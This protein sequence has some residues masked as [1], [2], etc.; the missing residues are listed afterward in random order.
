[1]TA[2][3]STLVD[4]L[5]RQ[6]ALRPGH[7]AIRRGERVL[8]FADLD[9]ESARLAQALR[10]MGVM[11]GDRVAC[12]S[13]H[14]IE[15]LLLTLAACRL[16]AV[17]MP[18]NWRLAPDEMAYIIDHGQA[19]FLMADAAFLDVVPHGQLPSLRQVV[20]TQ[21]AHGGVPGL[22]EWMAPYPAVLPPEA[23]SPH[24]DALQLYSSGTT[25]RP[26]GVVLTHRGLLS[27]C[28]TVAR[29]WQFAADDVN[30]NPLP[31]FH[32]AGM[33]MLLL[34]VWAGGQTVAF[35]TFEP[36]EFL[37]AIERDRITHAFLV[38]AMLLF[39]LQQ[40]GAEAANKGGLR[41]IAYGGS[42]ISETLLK[43]AMDAFR[44]DFLQVYG[45]TEVSGPIS[46]L[47]PEDHRAAL[48][49]PARTEQLRSA[50]RPAGGARLRIV[51]PLSAE[52]VP[53][54]A[55]G[56]I[57]VES[58]RNLKGYWRDEAAT[59]RAFPEGRS[60]PGGWLR[61][62]DA[63][64]LR[65][66]L[67]YIHDRIKDMIISGGENIYPAEVE[68]VLVAHPDVADGAII[69]VPDDTWGESVKACVVL[70]PGTSTTAADL[71]AFMRQRLAHFKCPRSV[72]FHVELPRNP[73]GKLL[74]RLL[75]EPYWRER[76]RAVN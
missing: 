49:D 34:T 40:P 3:D 4:T 21:G 58:V 2:P 19:S 68:N 61:T 75:R 64:Y 8:S 39:M 74:K 66:G 5:A 16:G 14:H 60:E 18:V 17:C 22:A 38:P 62:G 7:A 59:E 54:G 1:M 47:M 30:G 46:F 26:K 25:G 42:P 33:T 44:C 70:R 63:G 41:L 69:G 20:C 36:A 37:A 13:Q 9:A 76:T 57:W 31:T 29:D 24:D 65:D 73:S 27:T 23:L 6:V 71:I 12:L 52:P 32:V 43:Q 10:A 15:C 72:D 55:V 35:S 67:L 28:E 48:A 45:M 56:E 11:R 51:D 53:E 50:G